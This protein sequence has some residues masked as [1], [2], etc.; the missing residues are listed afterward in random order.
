MALGL[1]DLSDDTAQ[2]IDKMLLND[3]QI[4]IVAGKVDLTIPFLQFLK[5]KKN[6]VIC[7]EVS[8]RPSS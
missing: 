8:V 7:L 1:D 2:R 6:C 4:I 5:V 3:K